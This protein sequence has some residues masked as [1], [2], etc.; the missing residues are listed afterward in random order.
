MVSLKKLKNDRN[1]VAANL[2]KEKSGEAREGVIRVLGRILWGLDREIAW[3]EAGNKRADY[4]HD[5]AGARE[6][7]K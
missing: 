7:I 5:P 4:K 6:A 3:I 1:A 2:E